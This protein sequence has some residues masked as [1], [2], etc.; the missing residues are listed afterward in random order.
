MRIF[1]I[2]EINGKIECIA[3]NNDIESGL[4]IYKASVITRNCET[5]LQ[6][7]DFS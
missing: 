7:G 1:R 3:T 4:Y 2:D 5:K 6:S